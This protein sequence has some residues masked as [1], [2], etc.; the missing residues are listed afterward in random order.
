VALALIATGAPAAAPAQD[1]TKPERL[2]DAYPLEDVSRSAPVPSTTPQPAAPP[3]SP[4]S[5]PMGATFA[6]GAGAAIAIV[7]LGGLLWS[8]MRRRR[9]RAGGD[10][11]PAPT[12][13][14]LERTAAPPASSRPRRFAR[15]GATSMASAS[16]ANVVGYVSLTAAEQE[17]DVSG[18]VEQ[19]AH[20]REACA[21][22]G[23]RLQEVLCDD[24]GALAGRQRPGLDE[25]ISRIDGGA[26]CLVVSALD[27][28]GRSALELGAV[29]R[30]LDEHEATVVSLDDGID[31]STRAGSQLAGV[32]A[33]VAE[34]ERALIAARTRSGLA[35]IRAQGR[36]ISRPAVTDQP[37][38]RERIGAMRKSGMTLQAIADA[39]NREGVPTLRGGALWRPSSVQAAAGYKRPPQHA[40]RGAPDRHAG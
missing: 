5:G 12:A 15:D 19:E 20:I 30:R 37:Q 40:Q 32:L 11:E 35:A 6:A 3:A 24:P 2:W 25:A 26:T 4:E 18:L 22:K 17:Q 34:R 13:A 9:N 8:S 39:L 23:W 1:K 27:R 7:A 10:P 38:L 14:P 33:G 29:L 28:L 31:T 16:L 21:R 36:P